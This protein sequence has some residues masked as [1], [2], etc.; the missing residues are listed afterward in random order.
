[1]RKRHGSGKQRSR[2]QPGQR[3]RQ[4]LEPRVARVGPERFGIVA[5]DCG[6][7]EICLSVRNFY[8]T[9]LLEPQTFAVSK[10]GLGLA[11]S[12]IAETLKQHGVRDQICAIEMTGR[13]HRPIQAA[14]RA[15][16]Y[17]VHYIHPLA[18]SLMRRSSDSGTKTDPIDTE[19]IYRAAVTGLGLQPEVLSDGEF[20]WRL[21]TRQRR[22]LVEKAATLKIQ[23]KETIEAYL[24]GFTNQWSDFWQTRVPCALACEFLSAEDLLQA[25]EARFR[26]A[27]KQVDAQ[28]HIGTIRKLRAWAHQ[29]AAADRCAETFQQYAQSLWRDLRAKWN[30]IGRLELD[31][32]GFLCRSRY[33]RLLAM[34]G[35]GVI[36]ASDYGAELG[37]MTNYATSRTICG[38]AGVYPSR[39]QSCQTDYPNGPLVNARNRTMRAALMRVAYNLYRCNDYYMAQGKTYKDSHEDRGPYVVVA[40]RFSRLSFYIVL[41]DEPIEHPALGRKEIVLRK[42]MEFFSQHGADA[43]VTIE[44]LSSAVKQ[45]PNWTLVIEKKQLQ[46]QHEE[47]KQKRQTRGVHAISELVAQALLRIE[48]RCDAAPEPTEATRETSVV[49]MEEGTHG[50]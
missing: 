25:D 18:S 34:T 28:V 47:L 49:I 13:Y 7:P 22:D 36:S 46:Q 48:Q 24:P 14:L 9:V 23:L 19:A 33:V 29:A 16:G 10:A 43:S 4:P 31:L 15:A 1:M 37:P 50:S 12:V 30:E 41:K 5:V 38:R 27:T 39:Y 8:G 3:R 26:D 40:N 32:A 20:Q 17:D 35:I 21:Q 45:L 2:K 11:C 44:S 6:K 42:L